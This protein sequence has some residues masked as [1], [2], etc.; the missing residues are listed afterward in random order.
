MIFVF[1]PS[2]NIKKKMIEYY[3]PLKKDKTPPYAI[4]QAADAD[5]TITLYESGKIVFQGLSADIDAKL[6]QEMEK[7]INKRTIVLEDTQ[8]GKVKQHDSLSKNSY[9]KSIST[10]GSDEVGTGDYFGPIIVTATYVDKKMI[11]LMQELGVNDSKKISDDRIKNIAP[12]LMENIP[13]VCFK[14]S[15]DEYNKLADKN[16]NKIKSILHNKVLLQLLD[17]INDY[18]EKIVIDQFVY[19]QKFYEHISDAP[20]RIKDVTFLTK[21]ESQVYSV[22]AASIISRYLFLSEM[23]KISEKVGKTIPLGA[24]IDVD[25]FGKEIVKT[26]GSDILQHI[27]KIN[28]KNTQKIL[29]AN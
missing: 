14:L 23:K 22:A 29:N 17:K 19:P 2:E 12:Q 3:A 28:F 7:N 25:T 16:M 21:A 24:G 6:W 26:E 11:P 18:P 20:K 1:K 8:G 9:F 5:T 10:A 15:N 27:A 13:Y 4:F